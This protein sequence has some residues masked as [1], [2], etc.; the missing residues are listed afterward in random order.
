MCPF[1]KFSFN[2]AFGKDLEAADVIKNDAKQLLVVRIPF[3]DGNSSNFDKKSS[4]L[5][6]LPATGIRI[7][8]EEIIAN[9]LHTVRGILHSDTC[10]DIQRQL[11][12]ACRIAVR[13]ARVRGQLGCGC[14]FHC[15]PDKKY[16]HSMRSVPKGSRSSGDSQHN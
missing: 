1:G 4:L 14:G 11:G 5:L 12:E 16:R 10:P 13:M 9:Q 2:V 6:V 3:Q 8:Y 7:A 15:F